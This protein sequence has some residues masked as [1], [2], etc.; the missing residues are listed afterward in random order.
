M[1]YRII[2]YATTPIEIAKLLQIRRYEL[3]I[4]GDV[5]G[6]IAGL[7]DRHLSKI[8]CGTKGLGGMSLPT[9]LTALGCQLVLVADDEKLP[10]VVKNYVDTIKSSVQAET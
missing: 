8:E 7:A 6:N 3:G 2:G 9:L 4:S 5:L 1:G 10:K